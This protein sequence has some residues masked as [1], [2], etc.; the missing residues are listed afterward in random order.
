MEQEYLSCV[1]E[2]FR[3]IKRTGE[4]AMQQLTLEEL[5]FSPASESNSI[6][7]LVKHLSGNMLSRWTDFLTTDGEKP[8]RDRDAEFEGSYASREALMKDWEKGWQVVFD[9][10]ASL[11][12]EDLLKTVTIRGENHTV[13]QA[14]QRQVIH[15]SYHIGQ[16]VYLAKLVKNEDWQNLT[17]PKG[18]SREYL[19]EMRKKIEQ[20]KIPQINGIQLDG[21][22]PAIFDSPTT[23]SSPFSMGCFFLLKP[24]YSIFIKYSYCWEGNKIYFIECG[25]NLLLNKKST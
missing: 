16:I 6:A 7:I 13:I 4:K 15:Y 19:E 24:Y 22:P 8:T 5:H 20:K 21:K 18:K 2:D 14:I 9:T 3:S 23:N 11:R 1:Q 17:I 25:I 12:P 10:I